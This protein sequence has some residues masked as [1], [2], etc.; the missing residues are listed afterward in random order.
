MRLSILVAGA[1]LLAMTGYAQAEGDAT[2][3]EAVFK[4][5]KVCH[6]VGP[7]AKNNVG[8][9]LTGVVGRKAG[10]SADFK[11]SQAMIDAGATK[12]ITWSDETI[13]QYL[14][15]P[16]TFVP[17]N[18]MLFVGLKDAAERADVIAYLKKFPQ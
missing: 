4:K 15:A 3:G 10:T 17:G 6:M 7:G 9:N 14:A 16:T 1:A 2:K 18:K 12:G 13:D 5:C 8:P 11:Y